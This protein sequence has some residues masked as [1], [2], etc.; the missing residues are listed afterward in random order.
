[1]IIMKFMNHIDSLELNSYTY[2]GHLGLLCK[3]NECQPGNG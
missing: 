3:C 2:E 1:M